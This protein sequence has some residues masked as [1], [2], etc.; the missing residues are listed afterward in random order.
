MSKS[1]GNAIAIREDA[2]S[3]THKIK[4]MPTD[5]ARVKLTD[6]GDP[7]KCPVFQLHQ[8]YSSADTQAWAAQGCRNAEFGCITCKQ[9]VID[10]IL[11]EQQPMLERAA[12]YVA[13]PKRVIEIVE[14]GTQRA[15]QTVRETMTDVRSAMGLNY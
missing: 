7:N 4:T 3:I 14:A 1:Y 10:S 11:R 9:P 13:N 15:R 8:V 2:A 6:K 5:P 12:P